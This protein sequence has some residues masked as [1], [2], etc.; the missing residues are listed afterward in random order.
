MLRQG[1]DYDSY[2]LSVREIVTGIAVYSV[3]AV[4]VSVLFF[5]SLIPCLV[6]TPGILVFLRKI[7]DGKCR[8]RKNKL[9]NEFKEMLL[10]LSANMAAGYS[11][12]KAFVPACHELD[13]MYQGKSYIRQEML[14]IINGLEMSSDVESLLRD[15]ADRSGLQDVKE[16]AHVV[17]VAKG[18]GGNLIRMMKKM[19]ENI[20]RRLE[21]E[22]EIDTMIASK[23]LEQNIMSAMPFVIILY[24]RVCNPGYMDALYGNAL[25]IA[26]MSACLVITAAM[27][28]WGR[29]ITDIHM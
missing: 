3:I 28:I 15:M 25:G 11:L 22:E 6:F 7:A 17:A 4:M 1:I 12:E 27:V 14:L 18:S 13:G 16:F 23:R 10:S 29:K 21:V 20:D 9:N 24:L 26:A 19:V 8:Q 5:D 2:K